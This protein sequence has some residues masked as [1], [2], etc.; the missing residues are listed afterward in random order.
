REGLHCL[1]INNKVS[2]ERLVL[3]QRHSQQSAAAAFL[4]KVATD[5]IARLIGL[6]IRDVS[7]MHNRLAAQQTGMCVV[8]SDRLG[9]ARQ[10]FGMRLRHALERGG[11]KALTLIGP[12]D[13]EGCVAQAQGLL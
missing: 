12:K 7:N 11:M 1:A 4:D 13:T 8:L 2:E 9:R 3:A 5:R 10:E 6:V